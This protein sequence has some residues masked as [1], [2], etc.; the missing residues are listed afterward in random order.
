MDGEDSVIYLGSWEA[1]LFD[2]DNAD[3][4]D[5]YWLDEIIAKCKAEMQR[6]WGILDG[7]TQEAQ[8]LKIGY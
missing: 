7:L 3:K 2:I 5:V 1:L 6:R 4:H 8:E